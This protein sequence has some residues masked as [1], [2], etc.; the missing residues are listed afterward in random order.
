MIY[1]IGKQGISLLLLALANDGRA[2]TLGHGRHTCLV[3]GSRLEKLIS[4]S[5]FPLLFAFG[6]LSYKSQFPIRPLSRLLE[7]FPTTFI[8]ESSPSDS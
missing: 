3:Q 2:P 5:L 1:F 6:F 7:Q 4:I 8:P